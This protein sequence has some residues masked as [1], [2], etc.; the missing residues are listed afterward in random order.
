MDKS[1]IVNKF[2][3]EGF[4]ISPAVLDQITEEKLNSILPTLKTKNFLVLSKLDEEEILKQS[5]EAPTVQPK[6]VELEITFSIKKSEPSKSFSVKDFVQYYNTKYAILKNILCTKLNP[7]SINKITPA[8]QSATVI[9]LISE[10]IVGGY[11]LEDPAGKI[12]IAYEKPLPKNSVLGFTGELKENKLHVTAVSYPD[13]PL[14]KKIKQIDFSLSFSIEKNLP[15]IKIN[16]TKEIKDFKTPCS[17]S[18]KKQQTINILAF[19]PETELKKA[20]AI[21]YL[22]LRYLPEP[23]APNENYI[24]SEEPDIFWLIQKEGW[25]ENYKG[26]KIIS[27]E[28]A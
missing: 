10:K 14:D 11:T 21:E 20:E 4:L 6:H 26:V 3:E 12:Q 13:I 2:L 17:I 18:I 22:K 9:G 1:E 16:K 28:L 23:I 15:C 19:K 8:A 24:I 27:G 7:I 25:Q 5:P